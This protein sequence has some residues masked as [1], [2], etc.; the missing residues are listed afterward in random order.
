MAQDLVNVPA[1]EALVRCLEAHDVRHVFGVPGGALTPLYEALRQ[2]TNITHVLAKHE[3]GAAFMANGYARVRRSLGVCVATTGPGGTNALTGIAAS[4]M[5][6][7]PVLLITGQVATRAVGRGPLQDSTSFG[8]DLVQVFRP[9]TKLSATIPHAE[10]MPALVRRAIRTALAD[11]RGPVHLSV[12]VDM[13]K[14]SVP[15]EH[16]PVHMQDGGAEG[17]ARLVDRAAVARLG[18]LLTHARRPAILVGHGASISGAAAELAAVAER[19][20]AP[21][22][23]TPKAKGLFPEDHPLSLGVFGFGGH[24]VAD[25]YLLGE[26]VDVLVVLGSSLGELVT[27]AWDRRFRPS[28]A[29]VQVDVDPAMLGNA[30]PVDLPIVGDVKAT[31]CELLEVLNA[32]T[33]SQRASQAEDLRRLRQESAIPPPIVTGLPTR[34]GMSPSAV[35]GALRA[36]LPDSTLVFVDSGNSVSWMGRYFRVREPHTYFLSM[37][38]AS[39]GHAVAGA[40]GGSCAAGSGRPVVAV[41]G[42]AAFAMNGMEV[43]TAVEHEL[44]VVWIVLNNGGH[45]MVSHGERLL[46]GGDDL[47]ACHFRAPFRAKEVAEALGA[48]GVRVSSAKDLEQATREAITRAG[49][50]VIEVLIDRDE[51]PP[52]LISRARTVGASVDEAAISVPPSR[53]R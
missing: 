11:R 33:G 45:G 43:H 44:P 3:E 29:L 22:A 41:V 39:M 30:F 2:R 42:D 32:I 6:S 9:V 40:V 24:P 16:E 19:L 17:V 51:M 23:T 52:S 7:V 27:H 37:G 21:V 12:P 4:Y 53:L 34:T 50:T 35:P 14:H 15:Y 20:Q 49:P 38:L 1:I 26:N 28:E 47:G 48:T 18:W 5:D 13:M 8:V 31:L 36:A 25:R 46:F 10:R